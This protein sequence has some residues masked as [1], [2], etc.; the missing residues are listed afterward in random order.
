[1]LGRVGKQ[2]RIHGVNPVRGK[3]HFMVGRI[4]EK[5]V[6]FEPGMKERGSYG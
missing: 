6:G 2:L 4:C 1:M 5:N 3:G